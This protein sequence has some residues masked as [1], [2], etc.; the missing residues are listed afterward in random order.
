MVGPTRMLNTPYASHLLTARS[1]LASTG[2]A[3]LSGSH[4]RVASSLR[5]GPDLSAS[6]APASFLALTAV[7]ALVVGVIVST[8]RALQETESARVQHANG[9][10][11][12]GVH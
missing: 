4:W 9:H 3:H 7:W 11:F 6:S 8:S 5:G 1:L 10:R 2:G 12:S